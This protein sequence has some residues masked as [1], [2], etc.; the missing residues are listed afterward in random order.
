MN[1]DP[2]LAI[3]VHQFDPVATKKH[4]DEEH[5]K[6]ELHERVLISIQETE[7]VDKGDLTVE[8]Q[9]CLLNLSL[10]RC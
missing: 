6:V 9:T 1:A 5:H 4:V 3:L 8:D 2:V 10:C 7:T